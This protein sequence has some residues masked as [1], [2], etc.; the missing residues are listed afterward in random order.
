M[1]SVLQFGG[2]LLR[3][4]LA[5]DWSRNDKHSRNFLWRSR[6]SGKD[7]KHCIRT[8][9]DFNVFGPWGR[10]S[11]HSLIF[12]PLNNSHLFTTATATKTCPNCQITSQQW[13]V[14]QQLTVYAKLHF[15]VEQVTK[16]DLY[17]HGWSLFVLSFCFIDTLWLI[18]AEISF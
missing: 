4:H 1:T 12:S 7:C 17:E 11:I 15:L 5:S 3:F 9:K 10:Q 14:D 13:P 16:L 18:Y 6:F 8:L 2:Y